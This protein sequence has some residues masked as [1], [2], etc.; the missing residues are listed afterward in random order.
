MKK[1]TDMKELNKQISGY[2]FRKRVRLFPEEKIA[3]AAVPMLV[4]SLT[5]IYFLTPP[6]PIETPIQT[7]IG[8]PDIPVNPESDFIYEF[9]NVLDGI[10]IKK[11][12]GESTHVNIPATIEGKE[13]V[14]LWGFSQQSASWL[15]FPP[16]HYNSVFNDKVEYIIMPD[17]VIW[18]AQH[19]FENCTSL[20]K[21]IIPDSVWHLGAYAFKGCINLSEIYISENINEIRW[22]T[23]ADCTSLEYVFL[24]E[25]L[26]TIWGS[27]FYDCENL[28]YVYIPNS[29]LGI[30]TRAFDGCEKLDIIVKPLEKGLVMCYNINYEL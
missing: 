8:I 10:V 19:T 3:I 14:G 21:I 18:I 9:G 30:G 4:I 6:P 22:Y 28:K 12:I 5:L 24:P 1:S 16:T 15:L 11:Y 26:T 13:V 7:P 2:N 17:S 29:V 25:G 20:K 23:F 27:A